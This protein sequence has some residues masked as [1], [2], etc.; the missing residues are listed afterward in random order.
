MIDKHLISCWYSID[1]L[2]KQNQSRQKTAVANVVAVSMVTIAFIVGA[3]MV[4]IYF[5][6][7]ASQNQSITSSSSPVASTTTVT[8]TQ[9]SSA[10]QTEGYATPVCNSPAGSTKITLIAERAKVT[11][12]K[13]VTYDGWSFNGTIPGPTI[14]VNLCENVEFTLINND[15]MAH[16][17]DFHAAQVNWAT[18]YAPV[19]PGKTLSFNFTPAYPGIF[20]YHCGVPP[21]LEHIA[22]GMYGVIIVN[23]TGS[24]A[25]PSAS[26]GT[27]VLIESEFYLNGQPGTDGSYTGNYTKMLAATPDYVVF[28][29][30]AFQYQINPIVVRPNQLVRLYVFNEGPNL[31]EAFH[32]IGGIMDTAYIDGNPLNVEHGLQTLSIPPA[33]GA[34]VDMYFTDPGGLNPFVNHAFAYAQAGAVGVFKVENSSYTNSTTT[35]GAAGVPVSIQPGSAVNTTTTFYSPATIT[36]VIGVNNTVTWTNNDDATHT[37]TADD[38]SFDSGFLNQGQTWS[39]TFT[40]PGTYSYHCSIHPWMKGTVIVKSG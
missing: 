20:M 33:G 19:L 8:T 26:G 12:A 6:M 9:Q 23:G 3:G 29:G 40:T 27:Y 37:I 2:L 10:L 4:S 14:W 7:Q 24:W 34:I 31:W 1:V 30:Q 39:Y 16:S 13:N 36:V 18:V 21:V 38:G 5:N 25:L 17:I 22:N 28:N 35:S 32:V 11:I 15:T